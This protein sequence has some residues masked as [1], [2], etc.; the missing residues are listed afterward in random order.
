VSDGEGGFLVGSAE[1]RVDGLSGQRY[2]SPDMIIH[3]VEEHG[4]APPADF[5]EGVLRD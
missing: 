1:I 3:Y 4:Y 2:A 5:V